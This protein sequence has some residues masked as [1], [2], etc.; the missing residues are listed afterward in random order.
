MRPMGV[1]QP[2]YQSAPYMGPGMMPVPATQPIQSVASVVRYAFWN[3]DL[4][5][6]KLVMQTRKLSLFTQC[7]SHDVCSSSERTSNAY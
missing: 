2:G 3:Y 5:I 7:Y 4:I 1:N 6:L